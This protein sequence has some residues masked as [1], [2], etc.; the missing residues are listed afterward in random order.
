[1]K[2]TNNLDL[3][4]IIRRAV[5]KD[6][7]DGPDASQWPD[8]L[9]VTTLIAPARIAALKATYDADLTQDVADSVYML[10]GTAVHHV[11]ERGATDGDIVEL[12][13]ETPVAGSVISGQ[14][15]HLGPRRRPDRLESDRIEVAA[16]LG[17]AA[18][19]LGLLVLQAQ[20]RSVEAPDMRHPERD[21]RDDPR[22]PLGPGEAA[23][24]HRRA[25]QGPPG[26]LGEPPPLHAG[27]DLGRSPLRKVVFRP[28]CLLSVE[29]NA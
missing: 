25:G 29:R 4:A 6:G 16:E 15:D 9:S 17:M 22:Q 24:L 20:V 12:R 19:R 14:L 5:E 10:M 21:N 26:R 1:M 8:R 11:I 13:L 7:Y 2:I 28:R 3:P 27:G 23:Q 18:K